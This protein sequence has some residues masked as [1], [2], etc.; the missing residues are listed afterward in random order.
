M[1][2]NVLKQ[3]LLE[4]KVSYGT[5]LTLPTPDVPDMLKLLGFDWFVFDMEHT[6]M[7]FEVVKTLEMTLSDSN[8][9]PLVRIGEVDQYLVKRAL[10]VG[11]RGIVAPLVN[12]PDE[13]RRLVEYAMYPPRGSRGSAPTRAADYGASFEEYLRRAND[14]L[15]IA[16][17]IETTRALS[18]A[19]S[20]IGT[21]G[22]D[23]GFAG[24]N[25]LA[26]SLGLPNDR[27]SPKVIDAL[28]KVVNACE[29][30]GK[31]P[32]TLAASPE[33]A[34]KFRELGFRFISLASDS[35]FLTFG[36]KKYLEALD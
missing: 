10:D 9:C 7:S 24:P 26:M 19:E 31:I 11:S 27:S 23:I 15:L 34:K 21:E 28:K 8:I 6:T 5:F 4:G 2:R 25:D 3:K 29:A 13:A 32:G 17:Q 18:L 35:R 22:V 20:I 14:E 12:S 33:E 30:T 36:A 1:K 16:V